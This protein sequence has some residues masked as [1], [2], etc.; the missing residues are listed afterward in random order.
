[1]K[2]TFD[3]LVSTIVLLIFL[4]MG[5]VLSFCIVLES[6]GG[7][8]Y[9]QERVGQLGQDLVLGHA[10]RWMVENMNDGP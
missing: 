9:F 4:P 6:K 3:I 7:V 8:F 10:L 5:L 2:R 1:M